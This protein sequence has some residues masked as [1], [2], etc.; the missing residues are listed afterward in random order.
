MSF[1]GQLHPYQVSA[2]EG[3]VSRRSMLVSYDMGLGKTVLTIA[4]VER[5]MDEGTIREPG[6][7]IVLSSLKY[8]WAEAISK[9]TSNS[10]RAL[11]VDGTPAQRAKQYAEATNWVESGIDYIILNYEQVVNDWDTVK[12]LPRGFVVLDEA[13]AIKSFRSK[14]SKRVKKLADAPVRF[15]L[16]GTPAENGKPEELFSIYQFVDKKILGNHQSFDQR[17]IV[18]NIFG[19]VERY[20]NLDELHSRLKPTMVRKRQ[21][22]ADVAPYLPETIQPDPVLIPFTAAGKKIYKR[23]AD[24]LLADLENAK[25]LGITGSFN[26]GAHYG[27]GG[28]NTMDPD[29]GKMLGRV[30]AKLTALRMYCCDP[31]LLDNADTEY[32]SEL[33]DEGF[34]FAKVPSA[35]LKRVVQYVNDHLEADDRNKVVIFTHWVGMTF[36]LRNQF[37]DKAVTYTGQMNAKQKEAAKR[38]F[39]TDPDVRVLVSSDAGGYGV[40]L[41]QANM[42]INYD[43]ADTSGTDTQRRA[44][45]KRAS[46][47][48]PTVKIQDFLMKGSIEERMHDALAQKSGVQAALIDGEG[49]GK[50][51]VFLLNL[52]S[53]SEFLR[54]S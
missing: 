7:V 32:V 19:G 41:P 26:I 11:V 8:Q 43:L 47:A 48:W 2:V 29:A 3:M 28:P 44:R 12:T 42:L 51:G 45:I 22:D 13:T 20:K 54:T 16:T 33:K 52:D 35:K 15:A 40:D 53:L 34:D 31:A 23:I 38:S 21:T 50:N 9:F 6:L 14:R 39:Q 46:S 10:S 4:A 37:G 27:V 36:T 17:Y 24:D 25:S 1:T 18:R 30:G 5:M 49:I